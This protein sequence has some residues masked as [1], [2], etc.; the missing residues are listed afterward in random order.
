MTNAP[1]RAAEAARISPEENKVNQLMATFR[2][3]A[4]KLTNGKLVKFKARDYEVSIKW[5]VGREVHFR[6]S[7]TKGKKTVVVWAETPTGISVDLREGNKSTQIGNYWPPQNEKQ[8]MRNLIIMLPKL[9]KILKQKGEVSEAHLRKE[10]RS[11]YDYMNKAK[12][13]LKNHLNVKIKGTKVSKPKMTKLIKIFERKSIGILEAS[14]HPKAS[15]L[16]LKKALEE[17]KKLENK[18]KRDIEHEVSK[19]IIQ[20]F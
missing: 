18:V 15:I 5:D 16:K 2:A 3:E 10:Y 6:A 1:K 14:T 19:E 11:A 4:K 9:T 7:F 13:N 17:V 20:N 8:G 12:D